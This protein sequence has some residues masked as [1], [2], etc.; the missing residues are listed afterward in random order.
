MLKS[1][2]TALLILTLAAPALAQPGMT[3]IRESARRAVLTQ[4]VTPAPPPRQRSW[5]ERHPVLTGTV[6]GASIGGSVGLFTC[7]LPYAEGGS[8]DSYTDTTGARGAG[9]AY[10][11]AWG[12]GIGALV[13]LVASTFVR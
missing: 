12:A 3:S 7:S 6:V 11:G 8:C 13:G 5:V 4:T 9:A 10:L 2:L 1:T